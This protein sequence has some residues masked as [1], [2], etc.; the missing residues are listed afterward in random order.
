[1]KCPKCGVNKLKQFHKWDEPAVTGKCSNCGYYRYRKVKMTVEEFERIVHSLVTS[2]L[3]IE[4]VADI[5]EE[6][7]DFIK[8]SYDNAVIR[9][10]AQ[11]ES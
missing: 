8:Q 7:V 9:R 11:D 6:P 3:T 5:A 1:M 10:S 2:G 4:Q